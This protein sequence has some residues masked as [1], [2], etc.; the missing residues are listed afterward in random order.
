MAAMAAC[1][2][3]GQSCMVLALRAGEAV[4]VAPCSYT[5][6]LYA[7][8]F[9]FFLFGELPAW[10]TI[11]GATVLLGSTLYLALRERRAPLPKAEPAR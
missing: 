1:T 6:I 5:R 4:A 9:G 2:T 7:T 10:S 11:V 3:L 8:A